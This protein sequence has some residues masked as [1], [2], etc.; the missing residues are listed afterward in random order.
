MKIVVLDSYTLNPGD[1]SWKGL[2]KF[3]DLID[4]N[5]CRTVGIGLRF[6]YG[7]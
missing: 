6:G 3:G 4:A 1:I 7:S 5:E 2:E